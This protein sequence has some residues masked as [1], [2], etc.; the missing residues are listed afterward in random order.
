MDSGHFTVHGTLRIASV[1]F[2]IISSGRV[3]MSNRISQQS[4]ST[5]RKF[6][7]DIHELESRLVLSQ[8]LLFPDGAHLVFPLFSR[9]PRTGGAALQ[10]GTVLTIGV[11][12]PTTNTAVFQSVGAGTSTVEW[13][14]RPARTFT[15]ADAALVQIG[16]ARRDEITFQLASPRTGPTAIAT[17]LPVAASTVSGRTL[18]HPTQAIRL[19]AA[20]RTSG[21]AV[22]SGSILTITVTARKTNTVELSSL[23]FGQVVQAEWNGGAVHNFAGVSTIIVDLKNGSRDL[24]GL[25]T[26]TTT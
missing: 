7:P 15:G 13:N 12:Q 18:A 17:G 14:G 11:G 6:L 26:T 8:Q 2:S 24:V 23:N 20:L 5:S 16:R 22:Q 9:L 25:D 19:A 1:D 4:P 21:T 10:S 3:S